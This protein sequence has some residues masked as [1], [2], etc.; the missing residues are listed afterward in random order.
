MRQSVCN[1]ESIE[2]HIVYPVETNN[3]DIWLILWFYVNYMITFLLFNTNTNAIY[4]NKQFPIKYCTCLQVNYILK[5]NETL[6]CVC[7]V[8]IVLIFTLSCPCVIVHLFRVFQ[9]QPHGPQLSGPGE[10]L[11]PD[12]RDL[13]VRSPVPPQL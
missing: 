7:F 11:P 10:S 3:F 4:R 8:A 9:P 5:V 2:K 1:I 6:T 13:Q 12:P